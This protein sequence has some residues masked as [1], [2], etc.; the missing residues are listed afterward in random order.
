MSKIA[1]SYRRSDSEDITG[2]IF[3]RLVQQFGKQTV[4]RDI[5]NIR[6]GIDFR[7]QIAE[8]LRT[9]D[10]LL[11]MI[12]PRWFGGATGG[13]RRIDDEADPVRIE[14]ETALKREI[15]I[16]PVLVGG[17]EMPKT[18]QLP[19]SLRD[20]AY[21]HAVTVDSGRDFD[22]HVEG[23]VRALDQLS[24]EDFERQPAIP[25]AFVSAAPGAAPKPSTA[26]RVAA[27]PQSKRTL[28]FTL[29]GLAV[30]TLALVSA[31]LYQQTR[32]KQQVQIQLPVQ[33]SPAVRLDT[34]PPSPQAMSTQA[35]A[36]APPSPLN[37]SPPTAVSSQQTPDVWLGQRPSYCGSTHTIDEREVCQ[38]PQLSALDVQLQSLY[39][40][41]RS[42][43]DSDKQIA[44]R[45]EQRVWIKQRSACVSDDACLLDTYRARIAQLRSWH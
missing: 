10:V 42:R 7:T 32:Q 9:T 2:R 19:E 33:A 12:G 5:D 45:D 37:V 40:A 41:L 24:G 11:V 3:D 17:I 21:R 36:A 18:K 20:L 16:I 23:L 1:I 31:F 30:V 26:Q 13:Q 22:H 28:A 6:P 34:T 38:N 8:A 15:P 27:P 4:F 25:F 14:V 44:L 39:D 43:L 29:T 35:I